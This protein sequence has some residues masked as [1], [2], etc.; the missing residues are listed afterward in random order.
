M[1]RGEVS[2]ASG[3]K[4]YTNKPR[5]VVIVQDDTFDTRLRYDLRLHDRSCRGAAL[6]GCPR[7]ERAQW[8][9]LALAADGRQDHHGPRSKVGEPI[10]RLDD[11]DLARLNQAAIVFLGLAV[12]PRQGRTRQ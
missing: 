10:G 3:S 7:T 5:L 1:K 6:S 11:E 2:A 4:D 12:S 8:A 9:A